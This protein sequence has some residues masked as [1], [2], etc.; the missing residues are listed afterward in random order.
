[1]LKGGSIY[2]AMVIGSE[3]IKGNMC[4]VVEL[5]KDLD[6]EGGR[7]LI[8]ESLDSRTGNISNQIRGKLKKKD[9]VTVKFLRRSYRSER[10]LFIVNAHY[11]EHDQLTYS[12]ALGLSYEVA[13]ENPHSNFVSDKVF[14]GRL[15]HPTEKGNNE[16]GMFVFDSKCKLHSGFLFGNLGSTGRGRAEG[17]IFLERIY[18]MLK[19]GDRALVRKVKETSVYFFNPLFYITEDD[20]ASFDGSPVFT[21]EDEGY[22]FDLPL[23]MVHDSGD[24][25]HLGG[26]IP[27]EILDSKS[28]KEW[29]YKDVIVENGDYSDAGLVTP[30]LR[31]SERGNGYLKVII[32]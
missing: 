6:P 29:R 1:M 32:E 25:L 11:S 21:R 12:D 2:K 22:L 7:G 19:R 10:P 15:L 3:S 13:T 31:I 24:D 4:P 8:I 16:W 27:Y 28:P 14:M 20:M 23:H 26:F 30:Q 5:N 18:P 17:S 9:M